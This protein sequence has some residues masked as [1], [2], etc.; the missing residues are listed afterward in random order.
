ML[1]GDISN[2]VEP[3][4]LVVFE[5]LIALPPDRQPL[6][7]FARRTGKMKRMVESL[8]VNEKMARVINDTVW[9][10]KYAV[11]VVT[12]LD[13]DFL[14]HVEKWLE[15]HALPVSNVI[16]ADRTVLSR[17]MVYRL[18]LVGIFSPEPRDALLFGSRCY[19]VN[20][21]APALVGGYSWR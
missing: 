10:H 13:P 11:D 21:E 18:D 6:L 2:R 20:P 19:T 15:H 3:R 4:L 7:R 16:A 5:G 14:P 17:E 8:Q 9:R 1:G 12:F